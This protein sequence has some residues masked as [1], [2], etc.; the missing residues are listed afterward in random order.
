VREHVTHTVVQVIRTFFLY[1]MQRA[2]LFLDRPSVL[3]GPARTRTYDWTLTAVKLSV[4]SNSFL[5]SI[6][7]PIFPHDG[8]LFDIFEQNNPGV[9]NA[10]EYSFFWG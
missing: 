1:N 5:R 3:V 4:P 7:C 9:A 8:V 6:T 10:E 2:I